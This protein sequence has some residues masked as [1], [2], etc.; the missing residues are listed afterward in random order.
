MDNQ[1]RLE[2]TFT[3]DGSIDGHDKLTIKERTGGY[4]N[5]G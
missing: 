4:V 1:E 5:V 3:K 2:N